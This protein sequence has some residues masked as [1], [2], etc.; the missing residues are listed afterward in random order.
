MCFKSLLENHSKN[1][2]F[3]FSYCSEKTIFKVFKMLFSPSRNHSWFF[4]CFLQHQKELCSKLWV[5]DSPRSSSLHPAGFAHTS[6]QVQGGI[7]VLWW[8]FWDPD[9]RI[10]KEIN[11]LPAWSGNTESF[12]PSIF[13]PC[14]RSC[15][16]GH[17]G[18]GIWEASKKAPV[19]LPLAVSV[20]SHGQTIDFCSDCNQS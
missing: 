9:M 16:P 20:L 5:E 7:P 1:L 10:Y 13:S 12:T 11:Y 4:L 15:A 6:N 14:R 8:S 18:A 19:L 17:V 3:H 2:W